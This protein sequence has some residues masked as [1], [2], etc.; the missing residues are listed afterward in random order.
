MNYKFLAV[1]KENFAVSKLNDLINGL[2]NED[3]KILTPL[4]LAELSGILSVK[5]SEAIA[6]WKA[7]V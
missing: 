1:N 4:Q 7:S 2:N 3:L 5:L 6:A